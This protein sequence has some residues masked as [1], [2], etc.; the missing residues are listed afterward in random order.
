MPLVE[1]QLSSPLSATAQS[2][3]MSTLSQSV[4]KI[5]GKPESYM[6]V[7]LRS[8]VPMLMGGSAEPTALVK[9]RSVGAISAPQSRELAGSITQSL[10][11]A[12]GLDDDRV[13]CLFE[14]VPGARW[15][16]GGQTFG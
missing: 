10:V 2:A 4:A 1:V 7:V 11:K 6:M 12:G 9:V 15:A 5:L 16:Q 14:G 3:L 8:E 13:Y